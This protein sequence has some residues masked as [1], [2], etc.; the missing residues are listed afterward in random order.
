MLITRFTQNLEERAHNNSFLYRLMLAYYKP[1]VKREISLAGICCS[2]KVLCIGGG[3][4]PM[5][6]ILMREYTGA[7][8]TV[9]DQCPCCVEAAR[10]FL[11]ERG[12]T[13]IEVVCCDGKKASCQDYSVVHLAM[14]VSP[15]EET[16]NSLMASAKENARF[17]VRIPK[18]IFRKL[19]EKGLDCNRAVESAK[20]SL[21]TNAGQTMMFMNH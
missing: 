9:V 14:Q 13:G 15:L 20:H 17:L 7:K 1:L 18:K 8:I 19:Y 11:A 10:H 2:D 4:C 5:T 6:A 21:F 3:F 16:L 12:I